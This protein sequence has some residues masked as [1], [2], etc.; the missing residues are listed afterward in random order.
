M[1]LDR[2]RVYRNICEKAWIDLY[3]LRFLCFWAYTTFSAAGIELGTGY[4]S[5]DPVDIKALKN[6]RCA[7][8][9]TMSQILQN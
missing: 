6:H 1:V 2:R 3:S 8:I 9:I 4:F 7:K 5:N